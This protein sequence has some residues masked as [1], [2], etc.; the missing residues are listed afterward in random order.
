MDD[1]SRYDILF[2]LPRGTYNAAEVGG[3]RTRTIRAGDAIEVECY[4]LTRIGPA[5][6]GEYERRKASRECQIRLNRRNAEK[7]IRR[8]I[9]AVRDEEGLVAFGAKTPSK[10]AM[11]GVEKEIRALSAGGHKVS[12]ILADPATRSGAAYR[13]GIPMCTQSTVSAWPRRMAR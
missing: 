4:P 3:I 9:D 11:D 1:A 7:K 5:A 12:V 6:R 8:L 13:S 2:D 10:E